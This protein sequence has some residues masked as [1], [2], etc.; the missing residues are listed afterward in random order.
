[1]NMMWDRKKQIGALV[2]KRRE[3]GGPIE[4][5]ASP[6]KSEVVKDEDGMPDGRHMAAQDMMGA[7]AE[8]SPEKLM[9][10]LANF[11]DLHLAQ[12]AKDDPRES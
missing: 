2:Q 6:M 11:M 4:I 1:M 5:S 3:G 12:P 7:M 10:A 8:K 9:T